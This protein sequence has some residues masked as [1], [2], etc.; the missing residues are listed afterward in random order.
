VEIMFTPAVP[1]L[2][3]HDLG[4]A[5][6]FSPASSAVP[7]RGGSRDD[8]EAHGRQAERAVGEATRLGGWM[9]GGG[10][11]GGCGGHG[12]SRDRGVVDAVRR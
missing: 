4:A 8:A 10:V 1:I 12:G 2:R 5:R 6:R 3:V 9:A 11:C 7:W